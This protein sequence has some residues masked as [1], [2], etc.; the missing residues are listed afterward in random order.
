MNILQQFDPTLL[1]ASDSYLRAWLDTRDSQFPSNGWEA[2]V[3]TGAWDSSHLEGWSRLHTGLKQLEEEGEHIKAF[4]CWWSELEAKLASEN[5]TWQEMKLGDGFG[6]NISSLLFSP[7][8]ARFKPDF[9]F[10]TPLECG[11][12][13]P[14]ILATRCRV[15]YRIF[16]GP[17]EHSP[18]R[19]TVEAIIKD[20]DFNLFDQDGNKIITLNELYELM[21]VFI[22]IAEGKENNLD[23]AKV[24]AEMFK[25][26][27]K[28]K[29]EV[30][31]L[32]EFKAG[33]VEH[34]VT[35]KDLEGEDPR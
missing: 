5:R 3:Y 2:E 29:D 23:L 25:L 1:L 18:A 4:D 35:G 14:Q 24:M 7:L 26:G 15:T 10:E 32:A 19:H 22:E 6:H 16:S 12:P 8:G 13:A 34:P 11:S 21:S 17:H 30:L 31:E 9:K 33:M 27:D 28:N 20:S